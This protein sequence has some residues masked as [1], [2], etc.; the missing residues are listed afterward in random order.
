MSGH[1][2][3]D[4]RDKEPP[5]RLRGPV[6][7]AAACLAGALLAGTPA[8]ADP[9]GLWLDK[10]GITIRVA[11]CGAALCGTVAA[12]PTRNDPETGQPWT[13]KRNPDP[14]RRTRPLVG[15][16]V[17][18]AMR[19]AGPGKWSGQLYNTDDGMSLT[20]SLIDSGTDVLRVEGCVGAGLC[21]GENLRRVKR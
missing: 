8:Q 7:A 11:Q 3:I 9:L 6:A 19:P 12:M 15:V 17:F 2:G 1:A 20:G 5:M 4:S 21:G 10:D 18:I 13:D 14:A 16:Q